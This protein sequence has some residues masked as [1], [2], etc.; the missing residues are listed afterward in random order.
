MAYGHGIGVSP[1]Y[2]RGML[3]EKGELR[4][5][6]KRGT[7]VYEGI[8]KVINGKAIFMRQC[9]CYKD[10]VKTIV[11]NLEKG[12]YDSYSKLFIEIP[13]PTP[14]TELHIQPQGTYI[15]AFYQGDWGKMSS[16]Y[17]EIFDYAKSHNL[18]LSGY[19]Y[20]MIINENVTDRKEDYIVQIEIPADF[21]G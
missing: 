1:N 13:F 18:S 12:D 10:V 14:K 19:S 9:L 3:Q 8:R 16:R 5:A 17:E 11:E 2:H 4:M 15:R 7:I 6:E 20:E 21:R